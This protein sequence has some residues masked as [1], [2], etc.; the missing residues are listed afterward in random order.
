MRASLAVAVLLL[1]FGLGHRFGVEEGARLAAARS[2]VRI[3]ASIT[4]DG[5]RTRSE[6]GTHSLGLGELAGEIL[7]RLDAAREE[8]AEAWEDCA[9]PGRWLRLGV[10]PPPEAAAALARNVR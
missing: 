8:R 9:V 3:I 2:E 4:G 7:R 10:V 5:S 1:A 6:V